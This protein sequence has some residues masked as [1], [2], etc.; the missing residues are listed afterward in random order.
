MNILLTSVGRRSYLVEYFKNE[1]KDKGKVYVANSTNQSSAFQYADEYVITPLI[2]DENYISFLKKYCLEKNISV[3]ISLFD[4]DL[5][6]LAKNKEEFKK[7]GVQVIVSEES[8]IK[9]C[10]DKWET[11][12]FLKGRKINVPKTYI[13]LKKVYEELKNENIN[14]PLILKPR[15]GM[16]SIGVYEAENIE[17]LEIFYQ[18]IERQIQKTYLKYESIQ[19]IGKN[20][21]IQE[22]LKGQEYGLDIIN[23]LNGN[24]I[25]TFVKKKI[26][27][28]AGETDCAEVI[29]S[30][31]LRNCGED[32]S[33]ALKH[34]A[35]L[36][37]DL[38]LVDNKPYILEMNARF[39]G[40]YPFSH[41]AG[42]NLPKAIIEWLENKEV[43]TE[44]ILNINYGILGQKDIKIT[45]L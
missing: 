32:I 4:I 43:K 35:N 2:Y 9:I 22:K 16:G 21:L 37:V 18:K 40:G 5:L 8:V 34:I 6:V 41:L 24:Y 3:I 23:D 1:L 30:V 45:R 27:M 36:D 17:E 42:A 19:T 14:F 13:D 20:V 28:R 39:G 38:F 12:L 25:T 11:F 44:E 7:I 31:K 26:A 10:N 29:D 33:K 15:W